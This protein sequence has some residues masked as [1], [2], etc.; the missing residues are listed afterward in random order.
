MNLPEA[1]EEMAAPPRPA[2]AKP[3]IS[4]IEP[5]WSRER[6]RRFW[7][8]SRRLIRALRRYQAAR[9]QGGPIGRLASRYWVLSHRFW[10]VVAQAE[11]PLNADIGGGLLMTHPNGVVIHPKARIGPN[12]LIMQQVTIGQNRQKLPVIGGHVDIGPGAK[13][14]GGITIGDHAQIGANAV[15][16]QDVPPWAVV[17]G[18]PARVIG[19]RRRPDP[20]A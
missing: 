11:L 4:A 15:V 12:C 10:T 7:D 1:E 17:V 14:L 20:D 9:A 6:P 16:L 3:P 2:Q 5:D 18:I 13:V 8:P 19:D